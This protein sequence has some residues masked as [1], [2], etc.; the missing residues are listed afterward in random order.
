MRILASRF[1]GGPTSGLTI[2]KTGWVGHS[3]ADRS[4]QTAAGRNPAGE[5]SERSVAFSS[6]RFDLGP[7]CGLRFGPWGPR[8]GGFREPERQESIGSMGVELSRIPKTFS[9][10]VRQIPCDA[11][12]VSSRTYP[13][14]FPFR[15]MNRRHHAQTCGFMIAPNAA[16]CKCGAGSSMMIDT[17]SG[18]RFARSRRRRMRRTCYRLPK[19]MASRASAQ[20]ATVAAGR[21]ARAGL[22]RSMQPSYH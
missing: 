12:S 18:R 11:F 7:C 2:R 19:T 20:R 14:G 10:H 5:S 1:S 17:R 16:G 22:D 9:P 3:F 6:F 4:G 8:R 15:P 13:C 21:I